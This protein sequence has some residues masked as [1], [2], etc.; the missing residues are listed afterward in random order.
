M[1]G[2]HLIPTTA[3][4]SVSIREKKFSY[5]LQ[6]ELQLGH[7]LHLDPGLGG[8]LVVQDVLRHQVLLELSRVLAAGI[9]PSPLTQACRYNSQTLGKYFRVSKLKIFQSLKTE[10]IS[11]SQN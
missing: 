5:L 3:F 1:I 9:A 2:K 10:N 7:D 6:L 4:V 8:A 11:E